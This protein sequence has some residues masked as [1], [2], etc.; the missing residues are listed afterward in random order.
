MAKSYEDSKERVK[1][2]IEQYAQ[3]GI[4][5]PSRNSFEKDLKAKDELSIFPYT[6]HARTGWYD[7]I[8]RD[9]DGLASRVLNRKGNAAKGAG[10]KG[11][12]PST[13]NTSSSSDTGALLKALGLANVESE[14]AS[15]DEERAA[16][17]KRDEA[18]QAAEQEY[19]NGHARRFR[20]FVARK[21][22]EADVE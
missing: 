6:Y 9:F 7:N 1:E 13:A 2:L 17:T 16:I 10:S 19:Q 15:S 3:S 5:K 20:Q 8:D 21:L 4:S 11:R 14:F 12:Q 18:N 22:N